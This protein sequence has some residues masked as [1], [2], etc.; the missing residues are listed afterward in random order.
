MMKTQAIE[1]F[2]VMN[3]QTLSTVNGGV[4]LGEAARAVAICTGTGALAGSAFPV[5]G[6]AG[7]A[8]LGALYYTGGWAIARTH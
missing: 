7:G 4:G 2:E 1:R 6:T 8:L 5:V 3:S